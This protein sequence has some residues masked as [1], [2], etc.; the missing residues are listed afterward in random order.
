MQGLFEEQ[1][2]QEGHDIP[3]FPTM[4]YCCSHCSS[5]LFPEPDTNASGTANT[6]QPL[7]TSP[8]LPARPN[9]WLP[10]TRDTSQPVHPQHKVMPSMS[11]RAY[12]R[13]LGSF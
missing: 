8:S 9:G 1:Q 13:A 12:P 10:I 6:Q 4:A 7:G 3:R 11:M 2:R 5:S